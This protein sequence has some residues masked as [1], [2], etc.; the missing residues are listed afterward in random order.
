MAAACQPLSRRRRMRRHKTH[1]LGLSGIAP[2]II[3]LTTLCKSNSWHKKA[4]LQ[5][6]HWGFV[7]A[8]SPL[9]RMRRKSAQLRKN[10]NTAGRG[11]RP[12]SLFRRAARLPSWT[13]IGSP[14]RGRPGARL[15]PPGETPALSPGSRRA[16]PRP[17]PARQRPRDGPPAQAPAPHAGRRAPAP[18]RPHCEGFQGGTASSGR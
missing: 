18:Q 10:D 6:W 3:C 13:R 5:S 2:L 8:T 9:R 12:Q 1:K 17:A 14:P 16:G 4:S 15:P 7:P 11:T